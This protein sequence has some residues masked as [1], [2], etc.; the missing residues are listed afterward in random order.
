MWP[1][2]KFEKCAEALLFEQKTSMFLLVTLLLWMQS[3]RTH[4]AHQQNNSVIVDTVRDKEPS[5][6]RSLNS[7]EILEKFIAVLVI[8]ENFLPGQNFGRVQ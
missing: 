7:T 8:L 4:Q 3:D 5:Y 2:D 1:H 6:N